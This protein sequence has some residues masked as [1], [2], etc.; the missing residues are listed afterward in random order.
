MGHFCPLSSFSLLLC[1]P[2]KSDAEIS[3]TGPDI[4]NRFIQCTEMQC[5]C[6]YACK[7]RW[8]F[9]ILCIALE[10]KHTNQGGPDLPGEENERGRKL[11]IYALF[12][13]KSFHRK[14]ARIFQK[15]RLV[16]GS[17]RFH[18]YRDRFR[19]DLKKNTRVILCCYA[20]WENITRYRKSITRRN[21][22]KQEI[23]FGQWNRNLFEQ[24]VLK[25]FTTLQWNDIN[26]HLEQHF[27]LASFRLSR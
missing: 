3:I 14:W 27:S 25:F 11:S 10:T 4:A 21:D 6:A 19:S 8:P 7:Y 24:I 9:A 20:R 5:A 1:R 23:L 26:V 18:L 15:H 17:V 16:E 22:F 13:R 12:H 2:L